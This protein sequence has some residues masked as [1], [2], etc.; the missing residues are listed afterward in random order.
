[1]SHFTAKP[2]RLR[3][4]TVAVAGLAVAGLALSACSSTPAEPEGPVDLRVALW[5]ANEAHHAVFNEIAD[6]FIAEHPDEVSSI[7]FD[8]YPLDE[9]PQ[10]LVT[11][12]SG[13]EAPDLAWVLNSNSREYIEEGV[14]ADVSDVL[15]ADADWDIDDIVPGTLDAWSKDGGIYAYPFST[16]PFGMYVNLDLLAEAGQDNPRDLIA[17]GDWTWDKVMEMAD[18]VAGA[19]GQGGVQIQTWNIW[20][21]LATIWDR[22]GAKPWSDD[23]S[24]ALFDSPE[25]VEFFTWVNENMFDRNGIV[26]PGETFDFTAGTAAFKIH[27]LSTSGSLDDSFAWDFVPLP[28]GPGGQVN[29]MNQAAIGVLA[30]SKHPELAAEFL[31][32]FTNKENAQKQAAF[33]PQP[34]ESLLTLDVLSA[35]A[36]KLNDEQITGTIIEPAKSALPLPVHPHYSQFAST[37]ASSLELISQPDADVEGILHDLQSSVEQYFG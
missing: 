20:I 8:A 6:A 37:V 35:A 25:M 3:R 27:L 30:Q 9:Y 33:F 17:S 31:D 1:M 21:E 22:F 11:Q 23:G 19:T 34:R 32:F 28:A 36:T 7:T 15:E 29:V 13:G 18:A 5:S 16:Q 14:L 2:P 12:V 10:A 24:E 26:R 4:A